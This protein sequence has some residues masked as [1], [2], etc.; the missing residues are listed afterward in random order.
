[1]FSESVEKI[2][3]S[4]STDLRKL[5][6]VIFEILK[7]IDRLCRDN[8]IEYWLDAGTLLGAVR[9]GGFIPWDD[10]CDICMKRDDYEKFEKIVEKNLSKELVYD[11]KYTENRCQLDIDIQPSFAK[12]YYLGHF[13]GYERASGE[14]CRGAFVDIFPCDPVN[15]KM[16]NKK[17]AKALNRISY[18]R[19]TKPKK[20]RDHIKKFLQSMKVENIWINYCRRKQ[21]NNS[22][23]SI[24]YGV[25][26]PFMNN[27][28]RHK[29][30]VVFPLK[31]YNFEGEKFY[32]PSDYNTYLEKYY[33]DYMKFPPEEERVP[34]IIDLK[35]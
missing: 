13:T 15:E 33:G 25:D 11:N 34:H 35:L 14:K 12:I 29:N 26:T 1:M 17:W 7:E 30:E 18:F 24:V 2:I 21:K 32:G 20:I 8:N 19:K 31:E 9:H 4:D 6:L 10:D 22:T 27:R 5:Q 23:D 3:N 16:L 28:W